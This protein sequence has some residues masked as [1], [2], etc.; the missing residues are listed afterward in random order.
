MAEN[1][2]P[3][4]GSIEWLAVLDSDAGLVASCIIVPGRVQSAERVVLSPIGMN[5]AQ[6]IDHIFLA[7]KAS[8]VSLTVLYHEVEKIVR[9][10]ESSLRNSIVDNPT[11]P[12]D[13][14]AY[15]LCQ[16]APGPGEIA[17]TALETPGSHSPEVGRLS[18]LD[19]NER[20]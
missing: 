9:T 7:C 12:A 1:G 15:V 16:L 5:L 6:R 8:R 3:A 4:W 18:T 11:L 19:D 20:S 17:A 2:W 13:F 14:F 10:L